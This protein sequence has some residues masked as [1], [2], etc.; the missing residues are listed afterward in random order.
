VSLILSETSRLVDLWSR[1]LQHVW[2]DP[3]IGQALAIALILLPALLAFSF[4]TVFG[5]DAPVVDELDFV[6]YLRAA[7]VGALTLQA[8]FAQHWEHRIFFPRLVMLATASLTH[9]NTKANMYLYWLCLCGICALLFLAFTGVQ[10]TSVRA[11]LA[12]AP[13]AWLVFSLR[14][15]ENL[16]WGWEI[17]WGMT[18]LAVLLALYFLQLRSHPA[19]CFVLAAA[20]GVVASFSLLGGLV[21]W[22]VG[23]LEIAYLSR[24]PGSRATWLRLDL[25]MAIGGAVVVIYLY[26]YTSPPIV[27][28]PLLALHDPVNVLGYILGVLG[29]PL[30][31]D[32]RDAA[33]AIVV[34]GSLLLSAA[35]GPMRRRTT[36][37]AALW[38]AM[39][40]FGVVSAGVL[41]LGRSEFAD[42]GAT[43]SRYSLLGLIGVAGL[44]L[45]AVTSLDWNAKAGLLLGGALLGFLALGTLASYRDGLDQGYVQM[46]DRQALAG[47]IRQFET[48]PDQT[49]ER[50]H[51]GAAYDREQLAFLEQQHLS[52][53]NDLPNANHGRP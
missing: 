35:I 14:Q 41:A 45:W 16:L 29:E 40:A 20:S 30:A 51:Q 28:S 33:A 52:V 11:L 42:H 27:P 23:L 49:L 19:L 36:P 3:R 32:G 25:W 4:I 26:G 24:T 46:R 48:E 7:H 10:G 39:I 43:T 47:I 12:F 21:V 6:P 15:W 31:L 8:L 22:P 2:Q 5:V 13:V 9:F 18:V 34:L 17:S 44:Y 50:V 37:T 53:F 38:L 1:R